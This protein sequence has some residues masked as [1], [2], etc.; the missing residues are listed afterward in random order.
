MLIWREAQ[1][2][3]RRKGKCV[4]NGNVREWEKK[5]VRESLRGK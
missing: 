2:V 5:S 1:D 4:G 3:G